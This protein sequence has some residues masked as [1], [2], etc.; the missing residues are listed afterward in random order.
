MLAKDSL[1][2]WNSF[3]RG[4]EKCGLSS[5]QLPSLDH[6]VQFAPTSSLKANICLE[7]VFQIIVVDLKKIVLDTLGKIAANPGNQTTK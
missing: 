6:G 4:R 1:Y 7:M 3:S 5:T 2:L